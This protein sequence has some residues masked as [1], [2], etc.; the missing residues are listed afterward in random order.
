[1]RAERSACPRRAR[2]RFRAHVLAVVLA[3]SALPSLEARAQHTVRFIEL[4]DLG[5]TSPIA[6]GA[7]AAA[8]AGAYAVVG[9]DLSSLLYNPAGL[10]RVKRVDVELGLYSERHEADL[11]FYGEPRGIDSRAGS[12]E[13]AGVAFP[14]PV[15]RGSLV[16][17]AAVSR[18]YSANVDLH[19]RGPNEV[20]GTL[21]DFLLQQS[22]SLLAYNVGL[23]V[24]LSAAFSGGVSAFVLD[25]GVQSL[26][27]S[28]FRVVGAQPALEVFVTEDGSLDLRGFGARLG[29]QFFVHRLVLVGVAYTS[30]TWIEARGER[31]IEVVEHVENSIDRFTQIYEPVSATYLLPSRLDF[32]VALTLPWL[33]V[34]GEMAYTNWME[35][36]ADQRRFRAPNLETIFRE[37]FDV[38][39]GAEATLPWAPLRLRGGYAHRPYPTTFLQEDRITNDID[40]LVK[41]R[42]DNE[43]HDWA[44]GLGLL[45]GRVLTVDAAATLT[46]GA[47]SAE[48]VTDRRESWRY[49]LTAA[50]R[51]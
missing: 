28:D 6:C 3:A 20:E 30:P 44:G 48:H 47:R 37:V 7:R 11:T 21:D 36:A 15:Y 12:I 39:V 38:R 32:G 22:G 45:V 9:D 25:G 26:K 4:E 50:Y 18:P 23:G 19:Y 13:L 14:F 40:G 43:R 16:L 27:Q 1:V 29:G 24:D 2:Y 46:S 35:A 31:L 17:A 33:S 49:L 34:A 41:A 8:M 5:L 42:V 51:F 10:A